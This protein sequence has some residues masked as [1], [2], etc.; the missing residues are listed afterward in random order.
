AVATAGV[1]RREA[2][3]GSVW[4]DYWALTK[5][6]VNLLILITTGAAFCMARPRVFPSPSL[7]DLL[8]TLAGTLFVASGAAALNQWMERRYD[9]HMR[10][11]ARRPVAGGRIPA[12]HALVFGMLLSLAGILQ[13]R[14]A[15]G[16]LPS[17]LALATLMSYLFLYTPLKRISP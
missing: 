12:A 16:P 3:R 13:L 4:R 1:I 8:H 6:E 11:T 5:P 9:A 10:R 14:L 17:L 15:V 2:V 7:S